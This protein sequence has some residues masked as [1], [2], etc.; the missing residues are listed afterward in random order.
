MAS[1]EGV[2]ALGDNVI[3]SVYGLGTGFG[4]RPVPNLNSMGNYPS[5]SSAVGTVYKIGYN[6][7]NVTP[8]DK[9]GFKTECNFALDAGETFAVVNKDNILITYVT[10]P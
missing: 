1:P 4:V 5:P 8:G 2:T 3:I 10:P 7:Y 6:V 9:V